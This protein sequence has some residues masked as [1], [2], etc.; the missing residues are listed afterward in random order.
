MHTPLSADFRGEGN[1]H[2][3]YALE[4]TWTQ[5]CGT[6]LAG[7]VSYLCFSLSLPFYEMR[8]SC[9]TLY[10]PTDTPRQEEVGGLSMLAGAQ[11]NCV[12]CTVNIYMTFSEK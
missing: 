9:P 5:H 11:K 1:Q 6:D 7:P 10:C 8:D 12:I 3:A 2:M 4:E